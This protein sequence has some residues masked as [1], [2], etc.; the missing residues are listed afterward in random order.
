LQTCQV[1]FVLFNFLYRSCAHLLWIIL[2]LFGF[3]IFLS[4][5]FILLVLRLSGC[6][7]FCLILVP[8]LLPFRLRLLL[9][10]WLLANIVSLFNE[11]FLDVFITAKFFP[12]SGIKLKCFFAD[13]SGLDHLFRYF[14][15]IFVQHVM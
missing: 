4:R 9:A 3:G 6:Y 1:F 5:W 11:L 8:L 15:I 7:L 2:W 14:E 10:L 12:R 13:M